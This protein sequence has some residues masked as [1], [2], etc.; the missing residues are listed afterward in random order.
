MAKIVMLCVGIYLRGSGMEDPFVETEN[1]GLKVV[2]SV[3]EGSHYVRAF[4]GLLIGAEAVK[5]MRWDV[6][7]NVHNGEEDTIEQSAFFELSSLLMEKVPFAA[8]TYLNSCCKNEKL[9]HDFHSFITHASD[10]SSMCK[11]R[12]GFIDN[13][14]CV[15]AL[16]AA[17]RTGDWKG[18]LDTVENL[19][20]IFRACNSISYLCYATFYLQSMH[21]LSTTH[22]A[23]YEIFMKGSFVISE[24]HRKFSGVSPDIKLEQTI[25]LAQNSSSGIIG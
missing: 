6:F 19:L 20:S 22:P 23:S 10:T 4:R 13:I 17:D 5:S 16:I 18:H 14:N 25:Q 24:S 8:K 15:K 3:M 21:R 2:Q 12:N 11:Y 1:F 7:W 9:M